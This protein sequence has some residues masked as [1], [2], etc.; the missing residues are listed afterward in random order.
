MPPSNISEIFATYG[1]AMTIVACF[2]SLYWVFENELLSIGFNRTWGPD[3][4]RPFRLKAIDAT[5]RAN[6]SDGSNSDSFA[7]GISKSLVI[8]ILLYAIGQ[9]AQDLTDRL[10][11]S[12]LTQSL[13]TPLG[14][15]RAVLGCEEYHRVTTLFNSDGEPN[16]LFHD[17][18]DH[19]KEISDMI[20][21]GRYADAEIAAEILSNPDEFTNELAKAPDIWYQQLKASPHCDDAK[22]KTVG[23]VVNKIYYLAKNWA[24]TNSNYMNELLGI[25]NRID[26]SRSI[27][28][29]SFITF[30]ILIVAL[31]VRVLI[32]LILTPRHINL[33]GPVKAGEKSV[34]GNHRLMRCLITLAKGVQVLFGL[35]LLMVATYYGYSLAE[36]NFNERVFGYFASSLDLR[37]D[38]PAAP[39]VTRKI[40]AE[41][42]M[43]SSAEYKAC[44]ETVF[45][46]AKQVIDITKQG[47][48]RNAV[49][50]DLDET[51]LRNARFQGEMLFREKEF[52]QLEWDEWVRK[53][54]GDVELVPGAKS[55]VD[56]CKQKEI[57]V[58]AVSNRGASTLA[59]TKAALNI[60]GIDVSDECFKFEMGEGSSAKGGSS[61][62]ARFS[63]V[64]KEYN[65]VAYFGDQIGDFPGSEDDGSPSES[66]LWGS[67]YFAL[68]N[69]VYGSWEDKA[70][71][72]AT[73]NSLRRYAS[74]QP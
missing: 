64:E 71:H 68:P 42:W 73:V 25:Q 27:F 37:T 19:R 32:F 40:N 62:G 1:V 52:S 43:Q 24:F 16:G 46:S 39:T 12:S 41:L 35:F 18:F 38:N 57:L 26:F 54:A 20:P 23:K 60:N 66:T 13:V 55:F 2:W 45:N 44:C 61:K 7:L 48:R 58:I 36:N 29:V 70:P 21:P 34:E 51:I 10:V 5:D 15:A 49:I 50:I 8:F 63:A 56:W 14:S 33:A 22:I 9:I 3:W 69:P 74:C 4:L 11:D 31:G 65:V 6:V 67:R 17:V 28:V 30:Q 59:E 47:P 53:C 72:G